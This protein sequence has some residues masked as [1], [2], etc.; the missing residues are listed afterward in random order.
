MISKDELEKINQ[1]GLLNYLLMHATTLNPEI[2]E[3]NLKYIRKTGRVI[4]KKARKEKQREVKFLVSELRD[5]TRISEEYLK[6]FLR[7]LLH[8]NILT[9]AKKDK[10]E[11]CVEL[12]KNVY[13]ELTKKRAKEIMKEVTNAFTEEVAKKAAEKASR[14]A[15]R[16]ATKKQP[17]E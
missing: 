5:K 16:M 10:E 8:L 4:L 7:A 15:N 14:K 2:S 3:I 11:I 1:I 12:N 17:K 9:S 13:E 6:E